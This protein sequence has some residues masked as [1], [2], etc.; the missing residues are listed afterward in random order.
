MEGYKR[1]K[2]LTPKYL[3]EYYVPTGFNSKPYQW[4]INGGADTLREALNDCLSLVPTFHTRIIDNAMHVYR[5]IWL[6]H[7]NEIKVLD[8]ALQRFLTDLEIQEIDNNNSLKN[9]NKEKDCV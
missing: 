3:I 6:Q 5:V 9:L 7:T 2:M 8:Y 1:C 4:E